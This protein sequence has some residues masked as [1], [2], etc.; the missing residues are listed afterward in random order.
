MLS[1]LKCVYYKLKVLYLVH[2][3]FLLGSTAPCT[4]CYILRDLEG[5]DVGE[6]QEK[7]ISKSSTSEM[8]SQ[9]E[10]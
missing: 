7:G 2:I 1:F 10:K 9:A 4:A 3:V 6:K 8:A 5:V